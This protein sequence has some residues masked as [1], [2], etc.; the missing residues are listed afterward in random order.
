[1]LPPSSLN[2]ADNCTL[3]REVQRRY[4]DRLEAGHWSWP[5]PDDRY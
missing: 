4:R 1:M 3:V 5:V 2:R